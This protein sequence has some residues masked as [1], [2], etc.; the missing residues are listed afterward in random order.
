MA[1]SGKV[2][3]GFPAFTVPVSAPPSTA[4]PVDGEVVCHS[5]SSV[6]YVIVIT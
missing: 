2:K 6:V 1:A 4:G 5:S 3:V